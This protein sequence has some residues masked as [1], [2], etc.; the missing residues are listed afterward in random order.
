MRGV[1]ISLLAWIFLFLFSILPLH[2]LAYEVTQL[3]FGGIVVHLPSPSSCR[4]P[5]F[6]APLLS[7]L[8]LPFLYN[9]QMFN[10]YSSLCWDLCRGNNGSTL[11]EMMHGGVG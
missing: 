9:V 8:A 10:C 5:D 11:C 6:C 7:V 4:V 3:L 2:Q 1:T